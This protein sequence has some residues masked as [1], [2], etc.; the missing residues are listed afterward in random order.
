MPSSTFKYEKYA[1]VRKKDIYRVEYSVG[2]PEELDTEKNTCY[3]TSKASGKRYA[4]S[5]E[6]CTCPA[7]VKG[8]RCKHML[9]L[10][11]HLGYFDR[12]SVIQ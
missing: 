4:T 5:L 2:I 6:Q 3:F 9:A 1:N 10:A 8:Y 11:M 7:F 12:T